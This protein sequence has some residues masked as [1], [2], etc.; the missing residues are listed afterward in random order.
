LGEEGGILIALFRGS[1]HSPL[2]VHLI[3]RQF[4]I[5]V[6]VVFLLSFLRDFSVGLN[7]VDFYGIEIY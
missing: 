5:S 4:A 1:F 2:P 3:E 7:F 6:V